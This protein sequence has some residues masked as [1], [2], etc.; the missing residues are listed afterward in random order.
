MKRLILFS[1]LLIGYIASDAGV[2]G[3]PEPKKCALDY[4]DARLS[5]GSDYVIAELIYIEAPVMELDAPIVFGDRAVAH[6]DMIY[7]EPADRPPNDTYKWQSWRQDHAFTLLN[8]TR[9]DN[10][11]QLLKLD[12]LL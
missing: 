12:K 1:C 11:L 10:G 5:G 4:S 7:M 6:V 9:P 3:G 2:P 8:T